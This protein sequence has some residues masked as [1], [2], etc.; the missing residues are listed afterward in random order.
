M[1]LRWDK[2]SMNLVQDFE[3]IQRI[4]DVFMWRHGSMIGGSN[5]ILAMQSS[6]PQHPQRGRRFPFIN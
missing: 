6:W 5:H 4:Y 1:G 3:A 2:P